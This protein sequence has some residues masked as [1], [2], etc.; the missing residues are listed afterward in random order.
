MN[1]V[2]RKIVKRDWN[3]GWDFILQIAL[4]MSGS[5][6]ATGIVTMVSHLWIIFIEQLKAN[7]GPFQSLESISLGVTGFIGTSGND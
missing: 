3:V 5:S 6:V 4:C 7:V 2:S 1:I